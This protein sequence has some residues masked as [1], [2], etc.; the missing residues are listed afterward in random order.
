MYEGFRLGP[1]RMDRER[2][3][4]SYILIRYLRDHRSKDSFM[5]DRKRKEDTGS[6]YM[7]E[8]ILV[9]L[10]LSLTQ[11][12]RVLPHHTLPTSS[13]PLSASDPLGDGRV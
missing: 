12:T 10:C 1:D 7:R 8:P 6:D 4:E 2:V 3:S 5:K 11:S 9:A 13:H